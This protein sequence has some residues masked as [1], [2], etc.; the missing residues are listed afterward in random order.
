MQEKGDEKGEGGDVFY[1]IQSIIIVL[2]S[3]LFVAMWWEKQSP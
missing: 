1:Q 3:M 2:R